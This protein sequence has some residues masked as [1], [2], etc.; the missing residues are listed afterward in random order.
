MIRAALTVTLSLVSPPVAAGEIAIKCTGESTTFAASP[1]S[2]PSVKS[3][4]AP[5]QTFIINEDK[6]LVWRWLAPLNKRDLMCDDASCIATFTHSTIDL[7]W[8][9]KSDIL[10]WR[11]GLKL[12]RLTGH[13]VWYFQHSRPSEMHHVRVDMICSSTDLPVPAKT[14]RAF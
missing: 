5:D 14:A 12:D 4:L 11:N 13:G 2:E 9:P 7:F 8:E 10:R 1:R 3:E 6:K